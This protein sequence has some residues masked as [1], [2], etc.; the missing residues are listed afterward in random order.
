ME[1]KNQ[2]ITD[3]LMVLAQISGTSIV[4]DET[5][6]GNASFFFSEVDIKTALTSFLS[7]YRLYLREENGIYYVS[8]ILV[9]YNSGGQAVTVHGEDVEAPLVLRAISRSI[10]KTVTYDALPRDTVTIHAENVSP[11]RAVQLAVSRFPAYEVTEEDNLISVR[12]QDLPA[13][14]ARTGRQGQALRRDNLGHYSI[15]V[16]QARFNDLLETLLT[17]E[18]K[19]YVLL[20]RSDISLDRLRFQDKTFDEMLDLFLEQASVDYTVRNNIYYFFEIQRRDMN[21]K[22]RDTEI[23]FL[24]N[25]PVQDGV[26]LLPAELSNTSLFK[27]DRNTNSLILTGSKEEI[28]PIKDFISKIDVPMEGRQYYQYKTKY[29]SAK[30]LIPLIPARLLPFPPIALPNE[31]MFLVLF[32]S[33]GK[34]RFDLFMETIDQKDDAVPFTLKYLKNEDFLKYLPPSVSKTEIIDSGYPSLFFYT[35]PEAKRVSFF[36][37]LELLDKPQPQIKYD[38]LVVQYQ[39]TEDLDWS[40][41]LDVT[42]TLLPNLEPFAFLGSFGN[43]VSMGFDV[44]SEFGYTFAVKLNNKLSETKA[45]I[46][47]DTTLTALSGKEAKFQNTSTTRYRDLEINPDTGDLRSTGVTREV[48]SGLVLGLNG[49]V[50]GDGM[51]TVNVSASVSEQG[52]APSSSTNAPPPTSE[53]IVNTEL[54]TRSGEP[55]AIT[56][57]VQRKKTKN[58]SGVPF[59]RKIPLLGLLFKDKNDTEEELEMVIYVVPRVVNA[60]TGSSN[61][62]LAMN[63]LY[64]EFL[65]R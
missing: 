3:I 19:E 47:A 62:G 4:A 9:E 34:S 26:A 31:N 18:S 37:Q 22:F 30:E 61:P 40:R 42:K 50:S 17:N 65:K 16:P 20:F 53:R 15:D 46:Y 13:G 64:S 58:E 51:V 21:K 35:G 14:Q 44:V 60:L 25:I 63:R 38:I 27:I 55:I 29:L 33:E 59:L 2:S 45:N 57:L 12:R 8:K 54:R 24:L 56:G 23:V 49:W 43:L 36:R 6:T 52:S 1:F 5:V 39:K 32:D 48:S 11:L 28:T 41:N 7:A 10:A